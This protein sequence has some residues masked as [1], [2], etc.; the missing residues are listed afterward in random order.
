MDIFDEWW[1]F[2]TKCRVRTCYNYDKTNPDNCGQWR[3]LQ[4][5]L[6]EQVENEIQEPE[7]TFTINYYKGDLMVCRNDEYCEIIELYTN[8]D[9]DTGTDITN[10]TPVIVI[11]TKADESSTYVTKNDEGE[12]TSIVFT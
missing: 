5:C 4:Q 11:E 12:E 2:D 7:D 9:Q 3:L 10:F 8:P 6:P 1:E